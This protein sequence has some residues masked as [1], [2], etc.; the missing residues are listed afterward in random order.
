MR[1]KRRTTDRRIGASQSSH[2]KTK[3]FGA[4]DLCLAESSLTSTL[5]E[6]FSLIR[7]SHRRSDRITKLTQF[8]DMKRLNT[9]MIAFSKRPYRIYF[10]HIFSLF[11]LG[12]V[13]CD[14]E[15]ALNQQ[16]LEVAA[17]IFA[18]QGDPRPHLS[19]SELQIFFEG[20]AVATHRFS[21][22]DGL[23][24]Y[25]NV[26]FCGACH[27]KPAFGG[28]AGHYRDFYIYG[29]QVN[30][31]GFLPSG[32]R[33]GVLNTFLDPIEPTLTE[34]GSSKALIKV[35][36]EGGATVYTRRN[37]IP[38]FGIGLLAEIPEKELLSRADP[39]D[40]NGDGISGRP[41]YDQGY[42]G[43]FGLKAQTVSIENFIRGPLFNHLGITS[44]P[45]SAERQ[46]ALPVPSIAADRF[47]VMN[48]EL[49]IGKYPLI[50][51]GEPNADESVPI[52]ERLS[53]HQAAAPS[54]PLTDLDD[55]PDPELSEDELFALVSWAMLLAA[56]LPDI[57]DAQ[58][59]I[60][61]GHFVSMGCD[62][63][64][65]PALKGPRGL[66]PAYT[67][68]LLHDM[69][70]E[71]AD[72]VVM[73][74]A[75]GSEFRTQPLWGL[76]STGPYLYDGRAG[77]IDEAIALHGGEAAQSRE[78]Y[79]NSSQEDR[80]H[81]LAFLGTLGG[82]AQS[83]RGLIAP[84]DGPERI[85]ATPVEVGVP[86]EDFIELDQERFLNGQAIFD[87]DHS[88]SEGLGPVFNGD[89]CRGCHFDP[90]VGGSGPTGVSA[91]RFIPDQAESSPLDGSV[92]RRFKS[93]HGSPDRFPLNES[94][95]LTDG[96]AEVRQAL[97]TFG[98]GILS[99]ISEE[100]ILSNSDPDDVDGD[101]IRGIARRLEDGSLG[102]YGWRA[103]ISSIEDFVADA[104]AIELGFTIPESLNLSTAIY[105]DE[106]GAS[107]P[108]ISSDD[109]NDLA[110]FLRMLAPP[111]PQSLEGDIERGATLF[112]DL[113]CNACHIPKIEP[114]QLRAAYTDLLLHSVQPDGEKQ[115]LFRTTPLWALSLTGTYWHDGRADTIANAI[116]LHG[117]EARES[118]TAWSALSS[119]DKRSL[120][121]FLGSL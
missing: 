115:R 34:E 29:E 32:P 52:L 14:D 12:I 10:T 15:E 102:R 28:A 116:E 55:V 31:E 87:R 40:L 110:Y 23:G 42:V 85:G 3:I 81:L 92:I 20:E 73:A 63:C 59:E 101:G 86:L 93:G 74:L 17:N 111:T 105:Q 37:P 119:E 95:E 54:E 45:L 24:P 91:V 39:D 36:P 16:P 49:T 66:I 80:D 84:L 25:F 58:A 70:E 90:I 118:F 108:E 88:I 38:F 33:S 94:G 46:A 112:E 13:A 120:L 64:H 117:G 71:L 5:R 6:L 104:L 26:T 106:D 7:P 43:R 60:G 67:D 72:G 100:A 56:P 47:E 21:L 8:S 4:G 65:V 18:P 9:R 96:A 109:F 69:G 114:D 11:C 75:S 27:E 1:R 83:S 98:L 121:D 22:S 2:P 89:S 44:N 76:N 77:S 68:L 50:Q 57:P 53:F 103:Q 79:L 35:H 61:Q 51:E 78:L 99:A 82:R 41:N 48:Q 97:P 19:E 107:D 113:A 30:G 62:L